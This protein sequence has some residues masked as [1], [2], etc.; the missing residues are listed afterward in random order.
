MACTARLGKVCTGRTTLPRAVTYE[1]LSHYSPGRRRR[2]GGILMATLRSPSTGPSASTVNTYLPRY[3]SQSVFASHYSPENPRR[4]TGGT[5]EPHAAPQRPHETRQ[6]ET[7]LEPATLT[8]AGYR[9][10][11]VFGRGRKR[12]LN[13]YLPPISTVFHADPTESPRW[14]G[15]VPT[16]SKSAQFGRSA[17]GKCDLRRGRPSK[18]PTRRPQSR[19][20]TALAP[21]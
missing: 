21:G 17:R 1:F 3:V 18:W 15:G 16:G 10:Y 11:S 6:R 12:P 20:E 9:S 8:L 2:S 13:E 14:P 7:G 4:S 5:P 19:Q